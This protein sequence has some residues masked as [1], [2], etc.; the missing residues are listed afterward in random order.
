VSI[1]SGRR[2][3][4]SS[5]EPFELFERDA[6]ALRERSGA[7][8]ADPATLDETLHEAGAG[9]GLVLADAFAAGDE[10]FPVRVGRVLPA[11]YHSAGCLPVQTLAVLDPNSK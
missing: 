10:I 2:R 1:N 4:R 3:G 5:A 9:G 7:G 8:C 11:L 6:F